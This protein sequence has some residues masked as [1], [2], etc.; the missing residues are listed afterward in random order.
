VQLDGAL[1]APPIVVAVVDEFAGIGHGPYL[2]CDTG[3]NKAV[4]AAWPL[5]ECRLIY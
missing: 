3:G 2:A 4:A 5:P 1:V